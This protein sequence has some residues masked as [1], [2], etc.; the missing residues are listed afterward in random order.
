ME[1]S[2]TAEWADPISFTDENPMETGK[3]WLGRS[4][5]DGRPVGYVDDR[6]I[7]LVSGTRAGKGTTTIINNLCTWPGSVV[8]VDPKGE[9][10]TVTAARRGSGSEFCEGMGQSVHV[11]DPFRAADVDDRFRSR[12]NPLDVLDPESPLA[13]DEAGRLA[14]AIVVVNKQSKEPFW[15][16]SARNLVKGVILHVVT[17]P[18]FEG[19]RNLAT[20]REL[21]AR[22]DHEGVAYLKSKGRD[23]IP[24][25]QSLL[26]EGVSRNPALG[27]VI[28]GIG[29]TM[30]EL[31]LNDA[32]LFQGMLQSANR[33]TEFL[34]SPGMAD[35]VS[36]SDFKL[37]DLKT[38]PDGVS[39]YLSLPQRYM[40][41]HYRWLRMMVTLIVTEMEATK[42]QPATGHRVLMCLD[43]FAGLRRME[44]IENAVAQLAGFG[45]TML[46]VLQSLDQLKKEYENGWETFLANAGTKLFYGIGDH[47]TAEYVSKLIGETELVRE[48]A[49]SSTAEGTNRSTSRGEQRT[50]TK[51]ENQTTTSG[52]SRQSST[53][54]SESSATARSLTQTD[55]MTSGTGWSESRTKSEQWGSNRS[56]SDGESSSHNASWS[57]HPLLF[58]QTSRYL[59]LLRENESVNY[60]TSNNTGSTRGTSKGGGK[61]IAKGVSGNE[62]SSSSLAV[63]QTQ[64]STFGQTHS[65]SEGESE[66]QS[67]GMGRSESAGTTNSES[68]G[69]S[70]TATRGVNETILKRRLV[71]TDD[72]ILWFG[73][74]EDGAPGWALTVISGRRPAVVKR[75]KYFQ[76][77]FFGWLYDPHPDHDAPPKLLGEFRL[78]LDDPGAIIRRLIRLE[79][80]KRE[81]DLV[82]RG[83]TVAE[84]TVPG[85]GSV[86]L[87]GGL[88]GS[89]PDFPGVPRTQKEEARIP[90]LAAA[91]GVLHKIHIPDGSL[92]SDDFRLATITVNRR[93]LALLGDDPIEQPLAQ[94]VNYF[95]T[96][97]SHSVGN[98]AYAKIDQE[99]YEQKK[100]EEEAAAAAAQEA[101]RLEEERL[102]AER[103]EN[104]ARARES[105]EKHFAKIEAQGLIIRRALICVSVVLGG[106]CGLVIGLAA[107]GGAVLLAPVLAGAA[108]YGA[109]CGLKWL[110]E[111]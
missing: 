36:S 26:W 84:A 73:R 19:R 38:A 67:L 65:Q 103:E 82:E 91:A 45:I 39:L 79:W 25:A 68:Q 109:H 61:S 42:G 87:R 7:C 88:L 29:E 90:V 46:F 23:K 22:G 96:I 78:E 1:R 4:V 33:N 102:R 106:L 70:H 72:L 3:F 15:D 21:I 27:G 76:D 10:A 110:N 85:P 24:S 74:E 16:E 55:G 94:Y 104:E 8:V 17:D 108:G 100:R 77:P 2:A 30:V 83:E 80:L 59:P 31:A 44:V 12:F 95:T 64:T 92:P 75:T 43:E 93:Q 53:G 52:R 47:F 66:S 28:S 18:R 20:V 9:N 56:K 81:G 86:P 57:P 34:D 107:G 60:G 58:R 51:S 40:G 89:V 37:S 13:I 32:K 5:V 62:S 99:K 97:S 101:Q 48:T 69:V 35:C 71:T 11:L 54:T 14:D 41:E 50:T 111:K 63:G 49:T 105:R 98:Q 6:H